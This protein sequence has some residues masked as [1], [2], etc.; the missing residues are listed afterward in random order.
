MVAHLEICEPSVQ[1]S[2]SLNGRW[3]L[4]ADVVQRSTRVVSLNVLSSLDAMAH[5]DS[6]IQQASLGT[7]RSNLASVSVLEP[8]S[9][10]G[11]T[12][13]LE[14]GHGGMGLVYRAREV[15]LDRLVAVKGLPRPVR[16]APKPAN[17]PIR[18]LQPWPGC[19]NPRWCKSTAT[20]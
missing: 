3:N 16:S 10:S 20:M 17:E 12:D 11:L 5:A 18:K 4:V 2:G 15:D 6:S 7:G 1:L 13:L 8:P 9:I 19:D 14:V